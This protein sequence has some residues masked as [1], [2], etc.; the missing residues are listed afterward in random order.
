V[1]IIKGGEAD[2]ASGGHHIGGGECKEPGT[3]ASNLWKIWSTYKDVVYRRSSCLR[4]GPWPRWR[5]MSPPPR[6]GHVKSPPQRPPA[7]SLSGTAARKSSTVRH[8][9]VSYRRVPLQLLRCPRITRPKAACHEHLRLG[10]HSPQIRR[11]R[12]EMANEVG[13]FRGNA[14]TA[15]SWSTGACAVSL[16]R[17]GLLG[18]SP[19]LSPALN[20]RCTT[21][22]LLR[23]N[24]PVGGLERWSGS[25]R[26]PR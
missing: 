4:R 9:Y 21:P 17:P 5:S 26:N 19:R 6:R 12:V 23:I 15:K 25:R 3:C 24:R 14:E 18:N 1:D 13:T 2:Q 22:E 8:S 7:P 10:M 11:T 20:A 16:S